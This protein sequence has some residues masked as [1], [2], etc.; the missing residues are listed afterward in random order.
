MAKKEIKTTIIDF[1]FGKE[2][3]MIMFVGLALIFFGFFLMT[4]GGTSDPAV[5][6]DSIFSFQRITLAPVL[7]IAG[8]AVEVYAIM[9]KPKE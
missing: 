6:D 4:G 7:V 3:Y 1:P 2:N 9:K 5:W 8:L